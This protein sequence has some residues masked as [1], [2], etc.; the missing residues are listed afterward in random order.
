MYLERHRSSFI[1]VLLALALESLTQWHAT[2]LVA[3]EPPKVKYPT[4]APSATAS[5]TQ[6]L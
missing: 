6:P 3:V 1:H 5:I 2:L 4:N